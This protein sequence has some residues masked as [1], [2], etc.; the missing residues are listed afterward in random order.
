VNFNS[1]VLN[2]IQDNALGTILSPQKILKFKKLVSD[3]YKLCA[4]NNNDELLCWGYF[5]I[6]VPWST[7]ATSI[8]INSPRQVTKFGKIKDISFGSYDS[9]ATTDRICAITD[10]N[11]VFCS[12]NASVCR[13]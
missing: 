8:R 6:N 9:L 3:K 12:G 1:D 10:D 5:S 2:V 13:R 11:K 7:S 4:I